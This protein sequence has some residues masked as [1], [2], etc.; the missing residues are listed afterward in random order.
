MSRTI[1]IE[2]LVD[3]GAVFV[4][5]AEGVFA[6]TKDVETSIV[7]M[8]GGDDG[9]WWYMGSYH[10]FWLPKIIEAIGDKFYEA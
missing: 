7:T 4:G 3:L 1:S 8:Y 9:S 6:V 10:T 5:G 2:E